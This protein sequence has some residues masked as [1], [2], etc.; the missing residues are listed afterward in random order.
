MYTETCSCAHTMIRPDVSHQPQYRARVTA[1]THQDRNAP[2]SR[3]T[4]CVGTQ[5]GTP[6]GHRDRTGCWA[7]AWIEARKDEPLLDMPASRRTRE[8]LAT[9]PIQTRTCDSHGV[10]THASYRDR[11]NH[12]GMH[13][14]VLRPLQSPTRVHNTCGPGPEC[15]PGS[16]PGQAG[17]PHRDT[18]RIE[19]VQ[20]VETENHTAAKHFLQRHAHYCNPP[21]QATASPLV[22]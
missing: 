6:R 1:W 18:T 9:A 22:L 14:R 17:P 15:P 13:E 8:R 11:R 3:Y 5:R 7:A 12:V 10:A 2:A 4:R 21:P 16:T 20:H 19:P